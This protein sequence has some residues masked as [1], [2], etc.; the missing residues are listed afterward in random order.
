MKRGLRYVLIFALLFLGLGGPSPD[1]QDSSNAA[2]YY[3]RGRA[4]MV[5]EDWYSAMEAFI[6]CLRLNP[7]HAEGTAALTEC[8]YELG[9]FDEALLWA[10]KARS[11]ARGNTALAN[12]EAFI[13]IALGRLEGAEAVIAEVLTREPYNR[14]ALFAQ[15][16][17]DIAR[18]HASDAAARYR[19][20]VRRFPDDRRLL[21]SLALVLGS[22]GDRENAW[23]YTERALI[24]H[25]EDFRV[26]YYAAYLDA[27]GNRLNS[28]V[29]YAEQALFYRSGYTPARS[30]LASLRYR[31]G[32]FDE[33]ARLADE[34]IALDRNDTAAWY[35][36]GLAYSRMERNIDAVT[37]LST[38]SIIDPEDEF[39]RAA[40]EEL[41]ISET[42]PEDPLRNR[43]ADWHFIRAR[44]FRSRN[45]AEQALFEYRRGLR[46]NPYAADRREYAELLRMQGYPARYLEELKFMQD[47]GL[48]DRSLNDAVETYES[49]LEGALYRRW[50]VYPVDYFKRH[51]KVSVFSLASQSAFYHVDA[52]AMAASYV[53]DLLV[54]DRNISPMDTSLRQPSFSQA[55]RSAREADADYFLILSV[56]ENERD[57]SLKGEL[58][59]GRTGSPAGT[60]YAYRTGADRL[61]NASRNITD[62]LAAALPFRGELIQRRAA[63]GLINKGRADKVETGAVYEVVKKG[64]PLVLNEGIGLSYSTEDVVGTL[65]IGTA[66]EEVASGTLSRNGFFDR[67]EIGD[68]IILQKE[69]NDNPPPAENA[70]DPELRNLLRT[71]R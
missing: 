28:A 71:L 2:F 53:K 19:E 21:L 51:W 67:I 6:E 68:E 11:L 10:R 52:G 44:D 14:E 46:L 55:F 64:R 35:L 61:R 31:L 41:L 8:Y 15:A 47:L 57:L 7:A 17:L 70:V 29:R 34:L 56:T 60:F 42:N 24:Q 40:L 18:G 63:Q 50:S 26:Y 66:D 65:L 13:L 1:S 32:Q 23:Y 30:L 43:W 16:E 27:Q 20:A 12:L 38:A 69:K 4:S 5:E 48:A 9:E 39:I 54:H 22:L 49:L 25:P 45:L 33:A 62:Q 3:E 58:F 59:V 36:K 37:V